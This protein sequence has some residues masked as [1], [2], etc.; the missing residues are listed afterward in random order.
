MPQKTEYEVAVEEFE[1]ADAAYSAIVD[2]VETGKFLEPVLQRSLGN[3]ATAMD[4][5]A[6]MWE[7]LKAA[8][9]LRNSKLKAAKDALRQAVQLG[10]TQERGPDGKASVLLAGEF[11]VCSVTRRRLDVPSL[12]SLCAKFGILEEL[13]NLTFIDKN[14]VDI[15]AVLQV[16]EV[17]YERVS[18]WLRSKGLQ[19]ILDGS[20]EEVEKTPMVTGPKE[21]A[22][23]GESKE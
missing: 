21:V 20:Y 12:M 14:G 19:K 10:P 15:P 3:V 23:L 4:L 16:T 17:N 13:K 2:F 6:Q 1:K 7:Q 5:W 11:K 8:K 9:E 22:F 18:E